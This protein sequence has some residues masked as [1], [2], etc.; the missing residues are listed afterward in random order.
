MM[1]KT[2]IYLVFN[3]TDYQDTLECVRRNCHRYE[4]QN[5]KHFRQ[6]ISQQ[7]S[8][9]T[10]NMLFYSVLCFIQCDKYKQR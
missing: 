1:F 6:F 10:V 8:L 5:E 3:E 9:Y 7:T 2:K 4:E